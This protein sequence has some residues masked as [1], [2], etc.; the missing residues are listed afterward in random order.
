LL[1][2][3]WQTRVGTLKAAFKAYSFNKI[4]DVSIFFAM[5]LVY[6]AFSELNFIK[7]QYTVFLYNDYTVYALF[8]IRVIELISFFLLLAAFVKSAQ[9]GFHV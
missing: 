4:S 5:L 9:F 2:N 8:N 1:I 3:F 7:L 6:Y